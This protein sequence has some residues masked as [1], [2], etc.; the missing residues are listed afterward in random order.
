MA[1]AALQTVKLRVTRWLVR[2][3]HG[4]SQH[5]CEFRVGAPW[6]TCDLPGF[7]NEP[8]GPRKPG[9]LVSLLVSQ[10]SLFVSGLWWLLLCQ[11]RFHPGS[12]RLPDF[13][14]VCGKGPFD[15]ERMAGPLEKA[16]HPPDCHCPAPSF[17]SFWPHL[18]KESDPR[19][20]WL[21]PNPGLVVGWGF[22]GTKAESGR[23][24][25]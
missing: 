6:V 22:V 13:H 11:F 16:V 4:V 8:L 18:L 5:L 17:Q 21:K 25:R 1:G 15:G 24:F 3:W 14:W 20:F 7:K 19:G 12:P 9:G 2:V 23:L 10:E